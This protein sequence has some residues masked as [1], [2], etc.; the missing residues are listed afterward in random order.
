MV[1]LLMITR[2]TCRHMA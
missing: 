2:V 1:G